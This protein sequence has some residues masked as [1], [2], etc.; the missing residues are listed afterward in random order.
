MHYV[1]DCS[2]STKNKDCGKSR[3]VNMKKGEDDAEDDE[4][5]DM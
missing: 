4:L 2:S 1:S 5:S 3:K